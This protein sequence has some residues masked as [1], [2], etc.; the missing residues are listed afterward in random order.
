MAFI[1]M[2]SKKLVNPIEESYDPLIKQ[3]PKAR[4]RN[5]KLH[6]LPSKRTSL[7]LPLHEHGSPRLET[8]TDWKGAVSLRFRQLRGRI[9]L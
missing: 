1:H 3:N 4:E 6:P 5:R 7:L 8:A 9:L 2:A